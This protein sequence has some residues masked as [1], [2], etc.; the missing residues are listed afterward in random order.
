MCQDYSMCHQVW[1]YVVL[2]LT[3]AFVN[4]KKEPNH[5]SHIPNPKLPFW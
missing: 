4:A 5:H 3:K 1:F 2:G